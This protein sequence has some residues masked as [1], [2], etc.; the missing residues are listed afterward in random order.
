MANTYNNTTLPTTYF[1]DWKD[2]DHYHQMLFNTGRT[3][4][5]RELTQMQTIIN[6][7]IQKFADNIFKDGA[8][9]KPGGITINTGY[10][11][12]KLNTD[13]TAGGGA[14]PTT[15]YVGFTITGATSG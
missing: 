15:A 8:V 14:T 9:V 12:I 3:L 2:S 4:Q 7:D 11:F 6:K 13:T 5:A 10:E 1:D